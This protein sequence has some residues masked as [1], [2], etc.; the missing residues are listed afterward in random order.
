MQGAL[1]WRVGWPLAA[2]ALLALPMATLA[3][4]AVTGTLQTPAAGWT[5]MAAS[6]LTTTLLSGVLLFNLWEET[7]WAG[8]VQRRLSRLPQMM[9]TCEPR[10][11]A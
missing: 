5:A 2:A 10:N 4:A 3:M 7:A 11:G 1:R 6:Y 9:G 8:L